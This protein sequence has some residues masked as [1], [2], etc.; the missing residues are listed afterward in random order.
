MRS[1]AFSAI[2][3][4]GALVLPP[5]SL[6]MT[7]ASTTRNPGEPAHP[8][9]GVD[10][11]GLVRAHPAGAYRVVSAVRHPDHEGVDVRGRHA[12]RARLGLPAPIRGEGLVGQ[13]LPAH[14]E[15]P[16]VEAPV[17]PSVAR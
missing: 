13:D 9:S 4:V 5:T 6:G 7:E 15:R 8:Q 10:Y 14:L 2:M 3:M 17:A 16:A 1:A 12:V 11:R